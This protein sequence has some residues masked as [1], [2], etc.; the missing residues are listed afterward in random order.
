MANSQEISRVENKIIS[1][2][3]MPNDA[4]NVFRDENNFAL[5][6]RMA[7][8][9]CNSTIVPENYRGDKNIGNCVIALEIAS[10]M[11]M[12]PL[13][14][15]QNL[16]IIKGKPSW[17]AQFLIG[18]L[19]SSGRFSALRFEFKGESSNTDWGCRAYAKDKEGEI[20]YGT[21]VTM[22][23][24]TSEGWYGKNGSK[25]KTM[26]ELMLQYRAAAFFCRIYAPDLSLG[27]PT[28]DEVYDIPNNPQSENSELKAGLIADLESAFS[29]EDAEE[30][31]ETTGYA[32]VENTTETDN[33]AN[34]LEN[35]VTEQGVEMFSE[36]EPSAILD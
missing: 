13:S 9:L 2:E 17:S 7:K 15:M 29:G 18:K 14:V 12:S 34:Y 25:W 11:E 19:N 21:W 31:I 24:A 28:S 36:K 5:A 20:L 32:E 23:M 8:M 35:F 16:F 6:Q 27:L 33:S 22:K 1:T 10:K 30:N 26:P 4:L 3:L